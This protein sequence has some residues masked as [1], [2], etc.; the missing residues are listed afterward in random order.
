MPRPTTK[1]DLLFAAK[2]NYEKLN[3][4]FWKKHQKASLEEV[5]EMLQRSHNDVLA[6]IEGFSDKEL[7]TKG[8]YKWT[9]GSTLGAYFISSTASHYDWAI[10]KL[11][12][13]Q[14]KCKVKEAL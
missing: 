12:A 8:V 5:T 9:A 11:R 13:H 1:S 10:K 4:E 6:L 3:V 14:R 7:F 2:Q